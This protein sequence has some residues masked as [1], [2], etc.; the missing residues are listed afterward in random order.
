MRVAGGDDDRVWVGITSFTLKIAP[1]L[2]RD[3]HLDGAI[4]GDWRDF[5]L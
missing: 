2:W 3:P 4:A 5:V 1:Y